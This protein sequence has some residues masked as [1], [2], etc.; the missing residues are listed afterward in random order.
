VKLFYLAVYDS[1]T[2]E[3]VHEDVSENVYFYVKQLESYIKY[4][5]LSKLKEAYSFR[6]KEEK[7]FF[8]Q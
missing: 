6:F 4:P 2:K 5:H 7:Q 1:D 3:L 8:G